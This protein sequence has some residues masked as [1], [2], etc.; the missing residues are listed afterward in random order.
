MNDPIDMTPSKLDSE[1]GGGSEEEGLLIES[2][3]DTAENEVEPLAT[4]RF[5]NRRNSRVT[6]CVRFDSGGIS[7]G[8]L[9]R[10]GDYWDI[11]VRRGD[12][13]CWNTAGRCYPNCSLMCNP[14]GRYP[15][16]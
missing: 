15:V 7:C 8:T 13:Y 10:R 16:G 1:G 14:G 12:C 4:C 3:A 6:V 5:V 2:N 9:Q 11:H